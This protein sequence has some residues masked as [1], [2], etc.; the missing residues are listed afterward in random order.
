MKKIPL[1]FA[2]LSTVLLAACDGSDNGGECVGY[3][4]ADADELHARVIS[5]DDRYFTLRRAESECGYRFIS[6]DADPALVLW[7]NCM[8]DWK[9]LSDDKPAV[10]C[11]NR[12]N[13]KI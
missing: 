7:D 6:I 13:A 10:L 11:V 12:G 5:P 1:A 3:S 9:L 8:G 4:V 2:L